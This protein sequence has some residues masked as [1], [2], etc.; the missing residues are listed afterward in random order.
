MNIQWY[1]KNQDNS[2]SELSNSC[3][4]IEN[5]LGNYPDSKKG[6]KNLIISRKLLRNSLFSKLNS[7]L[8]INKPCSFNLGF[9]DGESLTTDQ[10]V[11]SSG[12]WIITNEHFNHIHDSLKDAV[13]LSSYAHNTLPTIG[14]QRHFGY[15][16]CAHS[17]SLGQ[18]LN[19]NKGAEVLIRQH[20]HVIFDLNVIKR[21]ELNNSKNP[22][23]GIDI[24]LA[25]HLARAT[26]LSSMNERFVIKFDEALYSENI[27]ELVSLLWW[28]YLEGLNFRISEKDQYVIHM[29]SSDQF[30]QPIKFMKSTQ[31]K[32]WSIEHPF[33]GENIPCSSEDFELMQN[34]GIPDF[35]LV[36]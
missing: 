27:E 32:Q 2:F 25:C 23:V 9:L 18:I 30:D 17:V 5:F 35:I 29:I 21:Q 6:S 24:M 13:L 15:S 34:G 3:Q 22:L 28:Y 1:S 33:T 14:Y 36:N 10:H 4:L 31:T 19:S 20:K 8:N 16:E 7:K 12:I 11:N 26:G